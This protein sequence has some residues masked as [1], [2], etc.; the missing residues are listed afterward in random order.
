MSPAKR[1]PQKPRPKPRSRRA[2]TQDA[3]LRRRGPVAID[4]GVLNDRL[5]YF[6]RRV[7]VWVFQDFIRRLVAASTSARR[8]SRCWW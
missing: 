3:M 4:L 2:V 1:A 5:G 8:S 7:Q 6:V